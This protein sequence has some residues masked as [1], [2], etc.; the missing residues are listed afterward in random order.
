MPLKALTA[1]ILR[2][3]NMS[4]RLKIL[5]IFVLAA[6][7]PLGILGLISYNSYFNTIQETVSSN[8]AVLASQLNKNLEL[9]FNNINTILDSGSEPL[10][11]NYL[12][13]TD[14]DAKYKYASEIG[15]R[16][17]LYKSIY[18]YESILQ[19]TNII[20]LSS[21]AISSRKGVY[22]Y[23]SDLTQNSI[24]QKVL[25]DPEKPHVFTEDTVYTEVLR[26]VDEKNVISVAKII[27]R[28]LTREVK[29]LI[30]VDIQRKAIEDI[31]SNIKLG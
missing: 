25:S 5:V 23:P 4:I 16:F 28:R 14:P 8:S 11:I 19:D 15:V 10:V 1:R 27:R 6:I 7:L 20:G 31:C 18:D 17:G 13:E 12:D 2:K 24:F 21:S 3:L 22:Y 26:R 29:G 30:I 9:F